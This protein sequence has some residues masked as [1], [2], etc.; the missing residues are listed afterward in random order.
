MDLNASSENTTKGH[1]PEVGWFY[2]RTA[3]WQL[4]NISLQSHDT[5]LV[6]HKELNPSS[7]DQGLTNTAL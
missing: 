6:I 3:T 1:S 2:G 7:K 5:V 4:D